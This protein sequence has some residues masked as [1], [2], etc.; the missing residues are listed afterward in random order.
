MSLAPAAMTQMSVVYALV[1]RETRTRFGA[2]QLGYLWALLEP[3]VWIL[4]FYTLF[5]LLGRTVPNGMD[6][7]SFITTGLVPFQLTMR[8]AE[9]STTAIS[10]NR[11]MLFYPQVKPLDLILA[12]T[13]LESMTLGIVF[14]LLVGG[15]AA[16]QQRPVI[17]SALTA[18]TGLSL[19]ALLGLSLGVLLCSLS[20]YSNAVE[21]LQGP[22]FRPLFWLSGVFFTADSLPSHARE[23]L[24]YNPILHN[25]E[26][27]REGWFPSY[28]AHH[29][30]PAYVLAWCGGCLLLGLILER[31]GRS[32][33][34]V[35]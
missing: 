30:S 7:A 25:V 17:D 3:V 15:A 9:R 22:L 12:R 1:L 11:A 32:R 10:A 6:I 31:S 24:L 13:A 4:S 28:N 21:R 34:E 14:L 27:T 19:A 2:H 29:A 16:F 18:M 5:A 23:L 26:L 33:I 20:V 35:V 8:T